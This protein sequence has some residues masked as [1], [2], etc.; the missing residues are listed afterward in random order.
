MNQVSKII[1]GLV[2]ILVGIIIGTNA[3]DITNINI[4]FSGWWTLFIIIPCFIGLFNKKEEFIGN[5]IGL[6]IGIVL[7]LTVRG[8]IDYEIVGALILPFIFIMI[9]LSIL[10]NN[11]IKKNISEKFR[12]IDKDGLETIV[13]TFAEQKIN[14]DNEKFTGT[15]LDAVFGSIVLDLE[16]ADLSKETII[17]SSSIFGGIKIILPNDVNIKIKSTPIFGGV[18]NKITNKKDN[19]KTIYIES[20]CLFGGLEIK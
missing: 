4:F 8:I 12:T 15:N 13:A 20:F 3:L 7:F 10:F 16:K 1:W 11:V 17:K 5:F 19:K 18:T 9:G 2:F 6:I 14:M